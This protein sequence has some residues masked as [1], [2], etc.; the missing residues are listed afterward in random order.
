[1]IR[2]TWNSVPDRLYSVKYSEDMI[3]WDL[4][5]DDGVL[6]ENDSGSTT[7]EF[8]LEEFPELQNLPKLFFRIEE[9]P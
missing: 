9:T 2:L 7:F 6:G 1:M 3:D 5:L 4:D 8:S